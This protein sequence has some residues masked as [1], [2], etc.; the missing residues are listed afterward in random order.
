MTFQRQLLCAA[1][2]A[3]LPAAV[4]A[5][6]DFTQFTATD[7]VAVSTIQGIAGAA[8]TAALDGVTRLAG[9]EVV[10]IHRNAAAAEALVRVDVTTATGSLIT[11]EA[12]IVADL[13]APYGPSLILE[14]G[15][16]SSPDNATLYL[17]DSFNGEFALIA[18]DVATGAASEVLRGA[19]LDDVS[20]FA[21]LPTGEI[22]VVRGGGGV[23]LVDP[24]GAP[25]TYTAKLAES[26]FQAV[27]ATTDPA[28]VESVAVDS[29][30][31][32]VY[33]FAHDVLELFVV[34]NILNA[35]PTVERLLVP[36]WPGAVD[37]HDLAVDGGG[38]LFGFD[39]ASESIRT[40][41]G[42]N[43]YDL[44][45]ADIGAAVDPGPP[46]AEFEPALWRGMGA[47]TLG[48]GSTQLLFSDAGGAL[49]L[50]TVT[51]P[52]AA[53]SVEDWSSY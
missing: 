5:S 22:V 3:A 21:V 23:G 34:R 50:V 33:L 16:E 20:D 35:T 45:N 6:V 13:G 26:D 27:L 25:A 42:V 29:A 17:M 49:G 14:G 47:R 18:V 9:N 44:S 37:F 19:D 12:D 10:V 24:T 40:W 38:N 11:T 53:A 51:F 1:V 46:P 39:E 28:P 36:G 8:D 15:F 52:A 2:L 7:A 30:T 31:G 48:D 41:D 43:A 4:A 32:D